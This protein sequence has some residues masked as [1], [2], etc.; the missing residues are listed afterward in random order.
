MQYI[1]FMLTKRGVWTDQWEYCIPVTPRQIPPLNPS[2]FLKPIRTSLDTLLSSLFLRQTLFTWFPD[3]PSA[4]N[5]KSSF[6]LHSNCNPSGEL[7]SPCKAGQNTLST[8]FSF[9]SFSS[10]FRWVGAPR[11]PFAPALFGTCAFRRLFQQNKLLFLDWSNITHFGR[12]AGRILVRSTQTL[13]SNSRV[14]LAVAGR[15]ATLYALLQRS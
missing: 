11:Q 5:Q 8:I 10:S 12:A 15:F 1:L 14:L 4:P 13:A 6:V 3:I 7:L 2:F 9:S